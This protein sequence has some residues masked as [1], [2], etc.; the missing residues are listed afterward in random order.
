MYVGSLLHT[1]ISL[2]PVFQGLSSV[3]L[4]NFRGFRDDCNWLTEK[5][6]ELAKALVDTLQTDYLS[7]LTS[8]ARSLEWSS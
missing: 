4:I 8:F 5:N 2:K 1:I 6:F 7:K 3:L